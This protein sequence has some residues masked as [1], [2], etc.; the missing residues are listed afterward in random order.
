MFN[1][2]FTYIKSEDKFKCMQDNM[3]CFDNDDI[4]YYYDDDNIKY[5][6]NDK[7]TKYS[8]YKFNNTQN[9]KELIN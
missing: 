9:K 2:K 1:G 5:C 7:K 3:P 8:D 6:I 4:P